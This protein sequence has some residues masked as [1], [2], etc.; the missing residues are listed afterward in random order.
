MITCHPGN[1]TIGALSG[2]MTFITFII[3]EYDFYLVISEIYLY[4]PEIG[5]LS[6]PPTCHPGNGPL[7]HYPGSHERY[8]YY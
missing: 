4:I 2:M 6:S 8:L 5:A 7:G 1:E 3:Q